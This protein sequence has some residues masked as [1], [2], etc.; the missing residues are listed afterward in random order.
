MKALLGPTGL[1]AGDDENRAIQRDAVASL[2]NKSNAEDLLDVFKAKG[3][4][5]L[6]VSLTQRTTR[7][8]PFDRICAKTLCP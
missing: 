7:H 4:Q 3:S 8:F 2:F 6:T 1:V 5:L